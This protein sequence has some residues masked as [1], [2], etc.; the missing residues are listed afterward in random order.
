MGYD[1]YS[2]GYGSTD[3]TDAAAGMVLGGLLFTIIIVLV[4][5]IIEIVAMWKLFSKAGQAG[6]KSLIPIY[7]TVILFKIAGLSP[8]LVLAFLASFIPFIGWLIVLA[9]QALLAY[10][11]AL[12]FGK[13]IGWA[14]GIFFLTPI[15]HMI[16]GLG[17]SQYVGP[18]TTNGV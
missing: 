2:S 7:N 10:K 9:L 16:L 5:A 11:L 15:F 13:D 18:V 12:A 4:I 1:Y 3:I 8:W 14:I 17:K 6:W